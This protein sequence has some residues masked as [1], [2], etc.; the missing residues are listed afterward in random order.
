MGSKLYSHNNQ[1]KFSIVLKTF[2]LFSFMVVKMAEIF[3]KNYWGEKV[4]HG[5][6][7]K[8]ELFVEIS[9]I[10]DPTP[11]FVNTKINKKCVE[12]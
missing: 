9:D 4:F 10:G 6:I 12:M 5:A 3:A 11:F 8:H 2:S 7:Q 1:K